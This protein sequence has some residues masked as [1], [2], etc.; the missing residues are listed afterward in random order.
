[1]ENKLIYKLH[2]INLGGVFQLDYSIIGNKLVFGCTDG[3]QVND[4]KGKIKEF[5]INNKV[6]AI[7]HHNSPH[8][9]ITHNGDIVNLGYCRGYN[10]NI[11]LAS[12]NTECAIYKF[13]DVQTF[14]ENKNNH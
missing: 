9:L 5:C 3:T 11:D 7:L 12:E 14:I 13:P 4:A 6:N 10:E 2:R 8:Y 1:M